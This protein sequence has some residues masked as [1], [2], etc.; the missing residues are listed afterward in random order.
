MPTPKNTAVLC[1]SVA[2]LWGLPGCA[3]S[4]SAS[5]PE[6]QV[7]EEALADSNDDATMLPAAGGWR[8]YNGV[9]FQIPEDWKETEAKVVDSKYI[10]STDDG[11][12]E[13]TLTSMRGGID[14]NLSR[15]RLQMQQAPG[16]VPEESVI[17]LDGVEAKMVDVRGVFNSRVGT[18]QVAKNSRLIGVA[19]PIRPMDF[20]V[21]LNGPRDAVANYYD[22][23][24]AFL[25][26]AQIEQ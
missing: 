13:V 21:K 20:Y 24:R 26:T 8:K 16:D 5:V 14:A 4:D 10:I 1:L 3:D 18:Q 6:I 17:T 2:T 15:W 23:F 22:D 19:L 9:S 12:L 7:V 11:D 25:K